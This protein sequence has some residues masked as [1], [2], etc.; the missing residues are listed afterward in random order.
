[1][2]SVTVSVVMSVYNNAASLKKTIDSILSQSMPDFEFIIVDDGSNDLVKKTLK[3]ARLNDP[4]IKVITQENRGIT[5]ALKVGCQQAEGTFIARQDNGDT[6]HPQRLS[7]Q[8]K[9][10]RQN[11]NTVMISCSTEFTGPLGEELYTVIQSEYDA[12]F[13]LRQTD[14]ETLKGPPHHGSVMFRRSVY[15]KVGGYRTQFQVAQD[16]DL[17]SRL[18]E[19]G[20]HRSLNDILYRA[21]VAQ[22]SIS[23]LRRDQQLLAT[24]AIIDCSASRKLHGHDKYTLEH[25]VKGLSNHKKTAQPNNITDSAYYYFLGSNLHQSN[26]DN[27][28]HYFRLAIESNKWHWKA[29]IKLL[30]GYVKKLSNGTPKQ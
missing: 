30:I 13:G 28:Q 2:K 5:N 12:E 26:F 6:S 8:L 11:L 4:R 25:Y 21:S 1:M 10:F 14:I 20:K 9:H 3:S 24:K 19:H 29:R 27:R 17:W 22:N 15:E 7:K 18:I 23:M 16:I